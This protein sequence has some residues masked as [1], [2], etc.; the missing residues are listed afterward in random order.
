MDNLSYNEASVID[1]SKAGN[2]DFTR[3]WPRWLEALWMIIEFI[4]VT[5]PL[6]VSSKLRIGV[7][8]IFGAKIG[9]GVI[10][11]ARTRIRFPWNLTIGDNCW[12]GEGVWISNKGKVVIGNNSVI[13]QESFITT[14][15]HEPYVTMDVIVKPIIIQDGVWITSRCIV[16]PGVTV[17]KNSI[18]TPGSV[19]NKDLKPNGIYGGN[20]AKFIKNRFHR[21]E[22]LNDHDHE[23]KENRLRHQL[24]SS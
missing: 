22:D 6:Q 20:P 18:V 7:L 10:M 3:T 5:N 24:L 8:R 2:G 11:R 17:G 14:G 12:I 1:L 4:L 19:V 13:S 9:S 15:S 23:E 21:E 16:L